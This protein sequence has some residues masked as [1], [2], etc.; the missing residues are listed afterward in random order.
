MSMGRGE[1]SKES[2]VLV[3]KRKVKFSKFEIKVNFE[4]FV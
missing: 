2:M 3:G 4:N 1:K